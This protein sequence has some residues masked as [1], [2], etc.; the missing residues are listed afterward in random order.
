MSV[1]KHRGVSVGFWTDDKVVALSPL[2]RLL[3]L[4]SWHYCCDSGHLDASPRE[5]KRKVLPDD[6][7]DGEVLVEEVVAQGLEMQDRARRYRDGD[8]RALPRPDRPAKTFCS[9]YCEFYGRCP[10]K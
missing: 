9:I 8:E 10:G 6:N 7:C 3:F 1:K 4:G 5:L 2:A